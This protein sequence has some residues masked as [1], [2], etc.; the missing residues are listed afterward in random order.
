MMESRL[1]L[2]DYRLEMGWT[3]VLG[4]GGGIYQGVP[5]LLWHTAAC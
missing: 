4:G 3:G 5:N 2:L 1:K